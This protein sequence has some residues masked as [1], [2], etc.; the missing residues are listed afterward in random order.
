MSSLWEPMANPSNAN[1]TSTFWETLDQ[2]GRPALGLVTSL[3]HGWAAGPTAELS[4]Y[5]LGAAPLTPGWREF[6][7]APQT[8]GLRSA[9]GKV[10][11]LHGAIEIEWRFDEEDLLT[12]SVEAPAHLDGMVFLPQPLLIASNETLF[13]VDGSKQKDGPFELKDGRIFVQQQRR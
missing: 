11:T 9:A 8:L 4:K 5:V 2:D 10:P 7:V 6:R 3:C 13:V 1:Y 12:L